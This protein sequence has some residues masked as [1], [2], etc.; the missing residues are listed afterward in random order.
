MADKRINELIERVSLQVRR[1]GA[2]SVLMSHAVAERFGLHTTDLECLDL[3]YLRGK[4]SAGE[5]AEATG[6]TSGAVTALID[7]LERAGYVIRELDPS[8]RRRRYVRIREEAIRPIEAVY[9]PM[10]ETMF[11]LWSS[12]SARDLLVIEDFLSRS[13]DA[14]VACVERLRRDS[15]PLKSANVPGA[16]VRTRK[17]RSNRDKR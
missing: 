14:S 6:L 16:G 15:A 8:D 13:A 17:K 7:R 12:F 3:I 5:L 1:V 9:E 11:K 2:Q 10:Q 4:A